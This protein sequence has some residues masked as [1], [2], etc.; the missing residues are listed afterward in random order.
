MR[1][2]SYNESSE[3]DSQLTLRVVWSFAADVS[4]VSSYRMAVEY[5]KLL[6]NKYSFAQVGKSMGAKRSC[7][8]IAWCLRAPEKAGFSFR[9]I[10][11]FVWSGKLLWSVLTRRRRSSGSHQ[12]TLRSVRTK[13]NF[14]SP[15][16]SYAICQEEE[17]WIWRLAQCPQSFHL[18]HH[19]PHLPGVVL[20]KLHTW[21]DKY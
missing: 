9:W 3:A 2:L 20:V 15:R 13:D 7:Q 14:K 1:D 12:R 8:V 18:H 5:Q 4:T 19:H 16:V 21:Y 10:P 6:V 17:G 11:I